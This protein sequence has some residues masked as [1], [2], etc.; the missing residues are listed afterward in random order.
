MKN[1]KKRREKNRKQVKEIKLIQTASHIVE[2]IECRWNRRSKIF[3]G[4]NVVSRS[5]NICDK[6]RNGKQCADIISRLGALLVQTISQSDCCGWVFVDGHVKTFNGLFS[7]L[8]ILL[9]VV[10]RQEYGVWH[11]EFIDKH[12]RVRAIGCHR[13]TR[14]KKKKK[15]HFL[16]ELNVIFFT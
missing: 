4:K 10:C 3:A 5:G 16:P 8:K 13:E 9:G 15:A 7:Q 14:K 6:N 1:K 11:Y 12:D 2:L